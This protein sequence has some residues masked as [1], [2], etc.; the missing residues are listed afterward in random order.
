MQPR[1]TSQ[2]PPTQ[3]VA[4]LPGWA[5]ASLRASTVRSAQAAAAT[6][7]PGTPAPQ[8][9]AALLTTL[10]LCA[11]FES[12]DNPTYETYKLQKASAC[13]LPLPPCRVLLPPC[14]R[15]RQPCVCSAAPAGA[16][17][18]VQDIKQSTDFLA[19]K[20]DAAVSTL[21]TAG[22]CNSWAGL[23]GAPGWWGT[24]TPGCSARDGH[25]PPWHAPRRAAEQRMNDKELNDFNNGLTAITDRYFEQCGAMNVRGRGLP[26]CSAGLG[27]PPLL[28]SCAHQTRR[29]RLSVPA[30]LPHRL[31]RG[32]PC[33]S[34]VPALPQPGAQ[35]AQRV[36]AGLCR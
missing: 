14:R 8:P 34:P 33:A 11:G 19:C 5:W 29:P 24:R 15:R 17:P 21:N 4:L 23:G 27:R 3:W 18:C 26:V 22:A 31:A 30:P 35:Q 1:W 12:K 2:V 6:A 9:R 32:L 10:S 36:Q 16:P 7:A 13:S 25:A 28:H 20:I